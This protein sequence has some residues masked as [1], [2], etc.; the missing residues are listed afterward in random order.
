MHT[1]AGETNK[2]NTKERKSKQ[3]C[4]KDSDGGKNGSESER[5]EETEMGSN[6]NIGSGC[7]LEGIPKLGES[8]KTNN[9]NDERRMER[10]QLS[11]ILGKGNNIKT[12]KNGIQ[13]LN[14]HEKSK[15][16][17]ERNADNQVIRVRVKAL[18]SRKEG[19]R[20]NMYSKFGQVARRI[21]YEKGIEILPAKE[22]DPGRSIIKSDMIPVNRE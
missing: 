17:V 4:T 2:S 12:L 7:V 14:E 19:S 3:E 16:N 5:E 11:D 15:N 22:D 9:T 13:T 6:G 1:M 21:L 8:G 10:E 20:I 18:V